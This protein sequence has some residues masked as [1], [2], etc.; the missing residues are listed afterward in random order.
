MNGHPAFKT[1]GEK[2]VSRARQQPFPVLG[3]QTSCTV[4]GGLTTH[5][6]CA[7]RTTGAEFECVV[8]TS[9]VKR[10]NT[11]QALVKCL[12]IKTVFLK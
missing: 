2:N 1:V 3:G 5:L 11:S 4:G 10:L 7:S 9:V 6:G 12:K 8:V